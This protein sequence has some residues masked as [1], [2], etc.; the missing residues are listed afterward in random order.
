MTDA[1]FEQSLR[2]YLRQFSEGF[3]PTLPIFRNGDGSINRERTLAL[4]CFANFKE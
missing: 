2:N 4:P 3:E 1:Q